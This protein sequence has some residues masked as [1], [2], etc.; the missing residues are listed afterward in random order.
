M[1]VPA[2]KRARNP[3]IDTHELKPTTFQDENV[4]ESQ[5]V[6]ES[7]SGSGSGSETT[8]VSFPEYPYGYHEESIRILDSVQN[9]FSSTTELQN[10]DDKL[11]NVFSKL[12]LL[13]VD[14]SMVERKIAKSMLSG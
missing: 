7:E 9:N 12:S 14:D 11:E 3:T 10:S 5:S 8:K 6:S 2:S 1:F 13:V 4:Y